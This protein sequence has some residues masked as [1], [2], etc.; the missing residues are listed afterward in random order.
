MLLSVIIPVYNEE[1]TIKKIVDLVVAAPV[2]KEVVLV[3]DGSKD[4]SGAKI[5]EIVAGFHISQFCERIVAITQNNAGKGAALKTGIAAATGD[6]ILFQDADLEY[7][8]KDYR[9]MIDPIIQ[10]KVRATM[11]S[12]LLFK[13]Q[14]IWANKGPLTFWREIGT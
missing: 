3:D 7:D 9:S 11:G 4:S 12:R 2:L 13:K 1:E 5:A 8:P 14:N 6:I 10:G